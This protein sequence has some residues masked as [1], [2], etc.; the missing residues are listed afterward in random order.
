MAIAGVSD[1]AWRPTRRTPRSPIGGAAATVSTMKIAAVGANAS[2][3][4]AY[5][6]SS[7]SNVST[8]NGRR[9]WVTPSPSALKLAATSD[10]SRGPLVRAA[11]NGMIPAALRL[12]NAPSSASTRAALNLNPSSNQTAG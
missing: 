12:P 2:T 4:M 10:T 5:T 11:S 6:S 3:P 1:S 7:A 8:T 9:P